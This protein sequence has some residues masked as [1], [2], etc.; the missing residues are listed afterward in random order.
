[1]KFNVYFDGAVKTVEASNE[2]EAA[3]AVTKDDYEEV[4]EHCETLDDYCGVWFEAGLELAVE[5]V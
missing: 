2:I 1:M 5:R 4:L 3:C